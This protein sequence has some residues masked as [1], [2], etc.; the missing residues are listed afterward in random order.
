M[1]SS[2]IISE[3]RRLEAD[4]ADVLDTVIRAAVSEQCPAGYPMLLRGKAEWTALAAAWNQG[5]DAHLEALTTRS[6]AD[7]TTGHVLVHPDELHVLLRRLYEDGSDEAWSLR[8]DI[9][10]TLEIEDT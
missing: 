4:P 5:I 8:S 10:S 1:I 3:I 6:S 7:H 2:T 9:L